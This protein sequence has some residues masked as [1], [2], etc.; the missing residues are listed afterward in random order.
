MAQGW[1]RLLA[2]VGWSAV[3]FATGKHGGGA[4]EHCGAPLRFAGMLQHCAARNAP[5][6]LRLNLRRLSI[7]WQHYALGGFGAPSIGFTDSLY[8][9]GIAL[10]SNK[11][12]ED[13]ELVHQTRK[14]K[15][16]QS[17]RF[18]EWVPLCG[19][20]GLSD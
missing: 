1:P 18:V 6:A 4:L 3:V 12:T 17:K 7:Y 15:M 13:I 20:C 5:P 9:I 10:A 2:Q 16:A 14:E 11:A 19:T 8:A